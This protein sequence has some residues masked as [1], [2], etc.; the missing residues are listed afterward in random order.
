MER[1]VIDL[2]NTRKTHLDAAQAALDAGN[3]EGYQASMALIRQLNA[4]IEGY[5]DLLAE[6]GRFEPSDSH[7][8]GVAQT[9]AA[10]KE[11]RETMRVQ[12]KLRS[13]NDYMNAFV[14]ALKDGI[15]PKSAIGAEAC[16]P[17]HNAMSVS[18]NSGKDGG[19]L[20]PLDFDN[21]IHDRMKQ[22]VD[23]SSLFTVE[24]VTGMQGWRVQSTGAPTA[25]PEVDELAEISDEN[26]PT[27]GKVTYSIRKF[28]DI[29]PVSRELLEGETVNLMS[30]LAGWFAPRLVAT[31]NN[32]L[33][34]CVKAALVAPTVVAAGSEVKSLKEALNVTLSTSD[35]A[36]A[37]LLTNSSGYN[38]LD[39][40]MD[41]HGRPLL[42]P[43]ISD[44]N[45][46]LFGGKQIH[47]LDDA[48]LTNVD[49]THAPLY[50]GNFA[51]LATLFQHGALEMA[52]TDVGGKAWR[53]ATVEIRAMAF[54]DA[55]V[56]DRTAA[57]ALSLTV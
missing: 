26:K 30:Y 5:Q 41:S 46:M 47:K 49:E 16:R 36:I 43:R 52:S 2:K 35:A 21:M 45:V 10:K 54:M 24:T 6:A 28:A 17:L 55:Q 8:F 53:S 25:I 9:V 57:A 29:L 48:Q 1:K 22:Y 19:F 42:N 4:E 14:S 56:F 3:T 15:N 44:P 18:G 32:L 38:A 51:A 34:S 27:L 50:V 7:M 23:L 12:D 40:L 11:E 20:V 39:Q 37:Q 13:G 33:L 31:K